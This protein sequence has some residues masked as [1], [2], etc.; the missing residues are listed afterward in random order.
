MESTDTQHRLMLQ[1]AY[2]A[3]EQSGYFGSPNQD[4]CNGSYIGVG[5]VDYENNIAGYPANAYLGTGNLRSSAAGRISH[6]FGWT[7]PVDT[8]CSSSAVAVHSAC[9]AILSG[10]CSGALAGGVNVMTSPEWF[11]NLAGASF[12]SPAGQCKPFDAKADG[13]CRGEGVGAVFLKKLSSAVA[14]GDQIFGVIAGSAVQ[15][16]QNCTPITVPNVIFLADLFV[17]ATRQTELES[18][19]ISIVKAHGTDTPVDDSAKYDNIRRVFEGRIRSDTLSLVSIKGLLDHAE[20]ASDIVALLKTLLMIHEDAIPPQSS[21]KTINPSIDA[22]L[23]DNIE[24]ATS[25]KP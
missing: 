22:S 9:R 15:Q 13:Y 23:S 7:G 5:L 16:N 11:Q 3:V 1:A 24:I 14:D 2:Q 19:Q 17:N 4:K 20:S 10:K 6:Y 25:L 12:L 21:F 18:Q 8:A